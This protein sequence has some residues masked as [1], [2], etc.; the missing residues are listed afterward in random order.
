MFFPSYELCIQ[1]VYGV[2]Q[3]SA[4]YAHKT[5][6]PPLSSTE[7]VLGEVATLALALFMIYPNYIMKLIFLILYETRSGDNSIKF[8]T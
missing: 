2:Q 4:C 1:I 6:S 8:V 5:L 3:R 7:V